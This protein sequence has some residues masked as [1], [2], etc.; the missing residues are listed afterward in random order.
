M[1][2][3]DGMDRWVREGIEHLKILII[4]STNPTYVRT[5]QDYIILQRAEVAV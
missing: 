4:M 2:E 5:K 3:W 1:D